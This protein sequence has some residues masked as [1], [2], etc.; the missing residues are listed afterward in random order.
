MEAGLKPPP[1]ILKSK[2]I[3][4]S[5]KISSP[6]KKKQKQNRG[7]SQTKQRSPSNEKCKSKKS[8]DKAT[9]SKSKTP[10][11]SS[12]NPRSTSKAPRSVSKTPRSESKNARTKSKTPKSDRSKSKTPRSDRSKSKTPRSTSKTSEKTPKK[13]TTK[14]AEG[15]TYAAKAASVPKAPKKVKP[16]K[17]KKFVQGQVDCKKCEGL[18]HQVYGKLGTMLTTF[19]K[20]VGAKNCRIINYKDESAPPLLNASQMPSDHVSVEQF[21]FFHG[22]PMEFNGLSIPEG[23]TRKIEFGFCLNADIEIEE[24]VH[25]VTVDLLDHQMQLAV[26]T[27]QAASHESLM[28]IVRVHNKFN[29]QKFGQELQDQLTKLQLEEFKTNKDGYLGTLESVGR[30]FPQIYVK[31]GYPHNGPWEKSRAGVDTRFKQMFI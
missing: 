9:R 26:K 21:F 4:T 7:R 14:A 30:H 27:C 1:S 22:P 17:N 28:H 10:R 23:R 5:P 13:N 2:T 19:Q 29:A 25:A 11:S 6:D 24:I 31:L 15:E 12:K 18:C 3:P 20:V 16:L 8:T